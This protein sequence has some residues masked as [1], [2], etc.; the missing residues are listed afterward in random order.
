MHQWG[1]A[2]DVYVD[3]ENRNRMEDLNRDGRVDVQ[4]AKCLYDE[5]ERMLARRRNSRSSRAAWAFIPARPRIR[6]SSMWTCAAPGAMAG[7][8]ENCHASRDPRSASPSRA[9]RETRPAYSVL[10]HEANIDALWDEPDRPLLA[11]RFP[12]ATPDEL[13]RARAYAYGGAVIQ[14]LGYYPFG[15][16]F[17]SNL[18]TTSE[19]AISSRRCIRDAQT[20]T[21]MRLRW[22]RSAHYTADNIG[23]PDGVNRAVALMFPKLRAKYGDAVT[24]ADSPAA[25]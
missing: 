21:N 11:R 24:Y 23:H 14:D 22:A 25:T 7:K 12:R 3:P 9:R 18:C 16:H 2:A 13:T 15:S 1:S 8:A 17:F 20:S 10:A 5:I 4:D 19:P 6:R